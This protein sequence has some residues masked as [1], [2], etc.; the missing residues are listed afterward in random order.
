MLNAT[1]VKRV[2]ITDELALFYVKPD[3][4]FPDFLPGQYVALGLPGAAPR[5]PQ[6][7]AEREVH[8][9]DKLIKRA[10]SIG[11]APHEK[12]YLEFYIAIVP[13]GGLTSRLAL[14]KEGDR[15]HAAP[16][17]TGTFTLKE[18]PEEKNLIMVSTGTG[19]APYMSMLR[20]PST[21]ARRDRIVLVHGVRYSKDLCYRD[22]LMQLA[23]Q[24][25]GFSYLAIVSREDPGWTGKKGRIQRLFEDKTILLTPTRDHVFLCGNPAMIDEMERLLVESNGYS[26]HSKKNPGNLHLERYW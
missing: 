18:I 16:K 14:L 26:V 8:A 6:F 3:K 5:P 19:I 21:W 25:P 22:E 24:R 12:E 13:D 7:P 4:E 11:S 17:I 10:Y 15:L 2:N 9:P 20:T 1:L 23:D